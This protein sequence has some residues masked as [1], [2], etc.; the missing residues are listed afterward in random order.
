MQALWLVDVL[1]IHLYNASSAKLA[2]RTNSLYFTLSPNSKQNVQARPTGKHQDLL[3]VPG[4]DKTATDRLSLAWRTDATAF[5]KTETY[6]WVC[7]HQWDK[8][9]NDKE[10][11]QQQIYMETLL[12]NSPSSWGEWRIFKAFNV[13]KDDYYSSGLPNCSR[14]VP[15]QEILGGINRNYS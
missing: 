14:Q 10:N 13:L 9:D 2:S 15:S 11:M 5:Q 7:K 8:I 6:A 3:E 1:L 4:S 12:K